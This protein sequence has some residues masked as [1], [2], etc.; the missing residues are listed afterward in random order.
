M[1]LLLLVFCLY[2]LKLSHSFFPF[3]FLC[4]CLFFFFTSLTTFYYKNMMFPQFYHKTGMSTAE[5]LLLS[6]T[7]NVGLKL[8]VEATSVA[9]PK[10]V[11]NISG[12]FEQN[13]M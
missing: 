2:T 10:G 1:Y 6:H 5:Q 9:A 4:A 8:S 3:P 11:F 12:L 13:H 7:G